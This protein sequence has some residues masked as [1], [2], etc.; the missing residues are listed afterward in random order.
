MQHSDSFQSFKREKVM[1]VIKTHP[2]CSEVIFPPILMIVIVFS[3]ILS[4]DL[5]FQI[6]AALFIVFLVAKLWTVFNSINILKIDF[7]ENTI[8]IISQNLFKRLISKP[9]KIAFREI[10]SFDIVEG[11]EYSSIEKRYIIYANLKSALKLPLT[12]ST[13][14]KNAQQIAMYLTGV[15]T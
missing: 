1:K 10:S 6:F 12:H 2:F 4:E 13:R 8:E 3:I 15:I 9:M 7:R 14:E 11:S 5:A